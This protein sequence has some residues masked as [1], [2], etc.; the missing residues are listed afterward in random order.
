MGAK[1]KKKSVVLAAA[2]AAGAAIVVAAIAGVKALQIATIGEAFAMQVPPPERV[3]A[4]DVEANRP[5]LKKA[6]LLTRD[7]RV[8]ERKKAGLKKARKAPQFSKR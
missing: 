4:V 3:N 7:A 8:I 2:G 1:S 6:G 5:V